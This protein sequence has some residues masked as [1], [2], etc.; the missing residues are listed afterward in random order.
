VLLILT[1][2]LTIVTL[3]LFIFVLNAMCFALTAW[4]IPGF[5]I[6]GFWP[7]LFG[8]LVVSVVSWILNGFF[9]GAG[10]VPGGRPRF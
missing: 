6:A 10:E 7:A 5:D 3:G 9:L 2:P 4:L 8:A 1:L